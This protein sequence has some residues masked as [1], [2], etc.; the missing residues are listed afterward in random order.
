[1]PVGFWRRVT[2]CCVLSR[3]L[4]SCWPIAS[5]RQ[6][7]IEMSVLM[8]AFSPPS[9]GQPSMSARSSFIILLP[10]PADEAACASLDVAPPLLDCHSRV[11]TFW[12]INVC[13]CTQ[14]D[15]HSNATGAQ[16]RVMAKRSFMMYNGERTWTRF[17]PHHLKNSHR[18]RKKLQLV[19]M[20]LRLASMNAEVDCWGT[21]ARLH[22]KSTFV[23]P[24][25][26]WG[27]NCGILNKVCVL[28]S[29]EFLFPVK[30]LKSNQSSSFYC[31]GM[32]KCF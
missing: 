18:G 26:S 27:S 17:L 24:L 9:G 29:A 20:E 21:T 25:F 6:F 1:M 7:S 11:L 23:F 28:V 31:F 32:L 5:C 8:V 2:H 22:I 13:L 10:F 30:M 15:I 3:N 14:R 4:K 19:A 12:R 16:S